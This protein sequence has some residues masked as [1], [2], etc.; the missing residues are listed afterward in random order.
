MPKTQVEERAGA[1]TPDSP[2]K[3]NFRTGPV[4]SRR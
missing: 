3:N 2:L 1:L 4:G